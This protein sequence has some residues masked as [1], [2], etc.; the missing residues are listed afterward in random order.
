MAAELRQE[1]LIAKRGPEHG[2]RRRRAVASERTQ[3]GCNIVPPRAA[4]LVYE[5]LTRPMVASA[6]NAP[7]DSCCWSLIMPRGRPCSRQY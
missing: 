6:S 2:V 4:G 3:L 5:S 1:L 7:A